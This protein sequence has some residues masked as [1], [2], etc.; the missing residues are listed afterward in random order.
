MYKFESDGSDLVCVRNNKLKSRLTRRDLDDIASCT[1][2]LASKAL[3]D[4]SY[5]LIHMVPFLLT[6]YRF[7]KSLPYDDQYRLMSYK[8]GGDKMFNGWLRNNRVVDTSV[9]ED[10]NPKDKYNVLLMENSQVRKVIGNLSN[11][12]DFPSFLQ[13]ATVTWKR[14]LKQKSD[15]LSGVQ[16]MVKHYCESLESLMKRFPKTPAPVVVFR[17]DNRSFRC[18][19]YQQVGCMSTSYTRF[20][21]QGQEQNL[22][23]YLPEGTQCFFLDNQYA[24]TFGNKKTLASEIWN[25]QEY[26]V[27]LPH[28]GF[29]Y[30][31][32]TEISDY[33][34][35]KTL[36]V[37]LLPNSRGSSCKQ[38][39]EVLTNSCTFS[40]FKKQ[41][42][43][44][45]LSY[46]S[47]TYLQEHLSTSAC[48]T[49]VLT[50]ILTAKYKKTGMDL[51]LF[52]ILLKKT[53]LV[54]FVYSA[55]F[56]LLSEVLFEDY[57]S[58]EYIS[59]CPVLMKDFLALLRVAQKE[60]DN[61]ELQKII[62]LV[63]RFLENV[64]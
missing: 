14:H 2:L 22:V 41:I 33:Y 27:L 63:E 6:Q 54:V 10:Y 53:E 24:E 17:V 52:K 19:V 26:E 42:S 15:P 21:F 13:K 7:F 51:T 44:I 37:H 4:P 60:D 56:K 16:N 20:L 32:D 29:Y 12:K 62:D 23:V 34:S 57:D 36:L 61:Y 28:G 38:W 25:V 30:V 64:C 3:D 39:A 58:G 55:L 1:E 48:F 49:K 46:E 40:A 35:A 50:S 47:T 31:A 45:D 59:Y 43:A 9:T 18:N 11:Y 8:Y 5:W